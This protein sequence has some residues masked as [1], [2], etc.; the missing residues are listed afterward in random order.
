MFDNLLH[1]SDIKIENK[2]FIDLVNIC[3]NN[4]PLSL[5]K[6]V[7]MDWIEATNEYSENTV[8]I[9]LEHCEAYSHFDTLYYDKDL[10][11]SNSAG[12]NNC[13]NDVYQQLSDK[14]YQ[15]V[16]ELAI[17]QIDKLLIK[18]QLDLYTTDD[19]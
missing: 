7:F 14:K 17:S 9:F 12:I 16:T 13:F 6:K 1:D 19:I 3:R 2:L 10:L 11:S 5:F 15:K 18:L 4:P 8:K